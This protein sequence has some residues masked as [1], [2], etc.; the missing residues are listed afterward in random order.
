MADNLY[1]YNGQQLDVGGGGGGSSSY[2]ILNG[3][4]WAV[5]GDSFTEGPGTGKITSG[6]YANKNHVYPYLIGNRC[7]MTILEDFFQSGK[8]LAYP[9]DGTFT[10][11][12]T[13][14]T[15]KSY[16]QNIPADVD[17]I[18][19]Y[20]G[21]N[22]LHHAGEGSDGEDTSGVIE[23]G[24]LYD[25]TTDTYYGAWNVVLTWLKQNRPFAH[26]GIIVTNGANENFR[27]A[28]IAIA[29]RYGVPY[30]DLNGDARTPIMIR[31]S[32]TN[33]PAAVKNAILLAQAVDYPSNTH[34]NDAA[35]L[36]ES[37]FIEQFLRT[38]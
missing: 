14:P 29:N 28:Q 3:K 1:R 37:Y 38:L 7:N 21:I 23:L 11:S 32:N 18:T 35:H 17:Y 27:N 16:Y 26:I 10:N 13:C 8:T 9:S 20:L 30:I 22:D 6:R 5:C 4:K 2:D 31:S 33:V 15:H 34:P 24:T 36:Y 25:N 19:I 12:L